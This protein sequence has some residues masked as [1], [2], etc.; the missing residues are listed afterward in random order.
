MSELPEHFM[1]RKNELLAK[2]E[3]APAGSPQRKEVERDARDLMA[4]LERHAADQSV[5]AL[6]KLSHTKPQKM[7]LMK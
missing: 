4:E 5:N 6:I 2:L 1:R 3:K 7:G